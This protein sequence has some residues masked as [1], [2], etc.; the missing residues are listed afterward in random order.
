MYK[1]ELK[2]AGNPLL[3]WPQLALEPAHHF[4]SSQGIGAVTL[5]APEYA[6]SDDAGR[7]R[8]NEMR[9]AIRACRS[10]GLAHA[11]KLLSIRARVNFKIGGVPQAE[12]SVVL[13]TTKGDHD[14]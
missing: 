14:P 9:P 12:H 3:R 11:A 5:R 1:S 13:W 6:R 4:V 10:F 2:R 8:W 7:Q